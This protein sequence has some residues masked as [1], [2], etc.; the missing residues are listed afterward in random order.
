MRLPLLAAI[1]LLAACSDQVRTE[2]TAE[3]SRLLAY[4]ARDPY[5]VI[6]ST[7]RDAD[8][9]LLVATSQGN[10]HVRYLIAPDDP[11]RPQLRLRR[12]EERMEEMRRKLEQ[13][14]EKRAEPGGKG[15]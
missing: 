12:M 6:D 11:A 15:A 13:G 7:E 2:M 14:A 3:E 5:V 8:G 10:G 9:Y 4:L 1:L